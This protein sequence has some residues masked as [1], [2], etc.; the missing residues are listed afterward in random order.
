MSTPQLTDDVLRATYEAVKAAGGNQTMAARALKLSRQALQNR[1]QHALTRLNLPPI[2]RPAAGVSGPVVLNPAEDQRLMTARADAARFRKAYTDVVRDRADEER[3]VGLFT[4][5]IA[6]MPA[7]PASHFTA[8]QGR[9]RNAKPQRKPEVPVLLRGDQQIG[10]EIT[11][12]ETYG[13]NRYNFEVFQQRLEAL[14]DRTLDIL[15][16]HQRADFPAIVVPYLGDNISGRIHV[17]LQKYGHQH[18]I[19]QVYLGAAAE[20]L[21]LYRL[22]KFGRW[23]E[24]HVPC[25]SGNHGRLDKEKEAKRYFK[26]FDYLFVNIMATFLRNVP[27]IKFHIPQC[28]FTIIEVAEH[29]ILVSHGHELPPSSL[30]IPLYS[31]NRA[32]ANYQEL[33]A[34]SKNERF[35]YW[36]MGHFHRPLEL[37]GSFVNGT[38]AGLSEFGIGKFKPIQPMQRLLGFHPTWG[39][40]W[41]YPVRLDRVQENSVYTFGPSMSTA[42]ALDMFAERTREADKDAA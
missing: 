8:R 23:S 15:N 13:I 31:I 35:N 42:D 9:L 38:M 11:F 25:V 36:F 7:I 4:K 21:F 32:S 27:Q 41:E 22:L 30:G 16:E 40:A 29:R 5:S 37:D 24:I 18:V 39:R 17:E 20:A 3:L 10:E 12:E 6:A 26:N 33:M 1:Y 34:L 28:L 2:E 14:E 19:D